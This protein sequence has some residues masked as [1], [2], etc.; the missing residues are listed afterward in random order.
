MIYATLALTIESLVINPDSS[1]FR[2][3][4][5][6]NEGGLGGQ[7][8][9]PLLSD[10]SHLTCK[11]YGVF[12]EE[13]GHSLRGLFIIDDKGIVRNVTINDLPVGRFGIKF[14]FCS[15]RYGQY[16]SMV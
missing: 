9:I 4:T 15:L 3:N 5:P 13:G 12:L 10:S 1:K 14:I 16:E 8:S 2:L 11:D 6:R 7:L